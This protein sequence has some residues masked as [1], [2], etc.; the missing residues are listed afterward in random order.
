MRALTMDEVLFVSGGETVVVPGVRNPLPPVIIEGAALSWTTYAPLVA[1]GGASVTVKLDLSFD[2]DE[3]V[4]RLGTTQTAGQA[5]LTL[6]ALV[7][8]S[9]T[10]TKD[11]SNTTTHTV[12]I[13]NYTFKVTDRGSDGSLEKLTVNTGGGVGSNYVFVPGSGFQPQAN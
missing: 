7:P 4:D 12:T 10:S 3:F 13:A 2:L 11:A 8:G 1:V 5:I 6:G 9:T